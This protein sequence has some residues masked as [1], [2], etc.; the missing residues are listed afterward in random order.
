VLDADDDT[1]KVRTAQHSMRHK[2]VMK[3]FPDHA[4]ATQMETTG[5]AT[6]AE[7][8]AAAATQ[9]AACVGR[10]SCWPAAEQQSSSLA[11]VWPSLP[12]RVDPALTSLAQSL[13]ASGR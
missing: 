10:R 3:W 2:H 6:A 4:I 9:Q 12:W 8:A 1:D 11:V 13:G 5:A 7:A